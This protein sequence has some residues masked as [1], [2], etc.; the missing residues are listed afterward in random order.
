MPNAAP[1]FSRVGVLRY[2]ARFELNG[3]EPMER[4]SIIA[5]QIREETRT[6]EK[7]VERLNALADE[8]EQAGT[9]EVSKEIEVPQGKMLLSMQ[10]V[11]E[12]MGISMIS[13][14]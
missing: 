10:E 7:T 14:R 4:N 11:S 2:G 12:T 3:V 5:K 13:Q 1:W 6:L 8:L 9:P